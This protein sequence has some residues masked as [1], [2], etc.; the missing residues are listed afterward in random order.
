VS[1]DAKKLR[2]LDRDKIFISIYESCKHRSNAVPEAAALTKTVIN[3]LMTNK[4]ENTTVIEKMEIRK[5]IITVLERYDTT[6][7][8]IYKAIHF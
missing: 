7:A 8:N 6:C 4:L 1:P 5:Q 3:I 2:A